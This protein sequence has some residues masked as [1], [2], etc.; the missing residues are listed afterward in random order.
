MIKNFAKNLIKSMQPFCGFLKHLVN[1]WQYSDLL[2]SILA[3]I[4]ISKC[5]HILFLIMFLSLEL[6]VNFVAV[7]CCFLLGVHLK[8][9]T[10]ATLYMYVYK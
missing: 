7:C 6:S 8:S 1:F 9:A 2:F 3:Y 5:Y 4:Y 10:S